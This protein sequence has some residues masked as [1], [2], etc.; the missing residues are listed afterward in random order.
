MLKLPMLI[1]AV[2]VA[3]AEIGMVE[4]SAARWV[5][6]PWVWSERGSEVADPAAELVPKAVSAVGAAKTGMP[7]RWSSLKES[8]PAPRVAT[9]P[10]AAVVGALPVSEGEP[11]VWSERA[12]VAAEPTFCAKPYVVSAGGALPEKLGMPCK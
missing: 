8:V 3:K 5:G 10:M 9:S 7:C 12:T 6:L 2:A 11:W 1:A 4:W